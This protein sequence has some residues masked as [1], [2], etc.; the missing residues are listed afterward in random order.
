[1]SLKPPGYRKRLLDATLERRLRGFGAIEVTG[2]KFCGKT[3]SSLAQGK[4]I[5]HIDEDAVRQMVELDA[6]LALEGDRPHV[7]DEWQDV[8][9]IWDAVR[10]R[11]DAEGNAKGQ[12]ILTG[13]STVNVEKLS[14]SGAGRIARVHMR[15][16]SLFESGHSDGSISLMG[17]FEGEFRPQQV[18]TDVRGLAKLI[19]DGGWPAS[20]DLDPDVAGDL[21][22]QYLDAL[23]GISAPKKGLDPSMS[24][25]V[26]LS[27]ARNTGKALTYKTL[28]ADVS[29][30]DVP[31]TADEGMFRKSL[32][33][34]ISFF[35]E[36]YFVED[37]AGWD[38]PIKSRSRVRTK[39]K[40]SFADPSLSASLLGVTPERLLLNMQVFGNL[41]EE[42]CLR[43]LRVYA[44][45]M[46]TMPEPSV[47]YYSDADGL[48]VDAVIELPDGRW[49]G[50]EVKLSEEKV[51]QA[52][53]NLLRL[54]A[55]VAANP[56]AHNRQPSFMA[57]LVGKAT[58]AR[59]TPEG[60][61]VLPITSLT[62]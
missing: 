50:I 25:R 13:S 26:A 30:G 22:A 57:V 3:W 54:R 51:P 18:L 45:A 58:F 17:L 46:Q 16:M 43:D 7:I 36:Q 23:F 52:E 12:F 20:L 48:E 53:K 39:P 1:M 29:E 32:E 11:V 35:K 59:T 2:P 42:L 47:C 61:H 24:R 37:Q 62:A 49:G 41:F 4:S 28:F 14:H 34:Y 10:R 38:A 40:R 15:P 33:P 27:L 8:P 44:S 19:C 60:I 6:A 21:P 9:K 31:T 5:I 56:A 55:K